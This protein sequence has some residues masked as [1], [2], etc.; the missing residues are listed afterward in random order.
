MSVH[1]F[2]AAGRRRRSAGRRQPSPPSGAAIGLLGCL[3]GSLVWAM[4]AAA[5]LL[6]GQLGWAL[7]GAAGLAA[8]AAGAVLCAL[9]VR[10]RGFHHRTRPGDDDHG[11]DGGAAVDPWP[12]APHGDGGEIVDWE[13]FQADFW[14][15]VAACERRGAA[16]P[17]RCVPPDAGRPCA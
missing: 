1:R 2:P 8:C 13:R 5:S 6:T 7:A 15:H 9:I 10:A 16:R 4:I 12:R 11:G 14:R 17:A 3:A